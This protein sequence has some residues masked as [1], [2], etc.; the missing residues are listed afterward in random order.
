MFHSIDS[1]NA[2]SSEYKVHRIFSEISNYIEFYK[3]L[4]FSVFAL[5]TPGTTAICNLDSYL[6]S[7]IQ[8]T[9]ESIKLVLQNGRINDSYSLARK[10]YDS[11]VINIYENL[12]L[13]DNFSINNFVVKKI[14]DWLHGK[15]KLPRY[16]AMMKYIQASKKL[17]KVNV[18]LDMEQNGHYG[19]IRKRCNDHAHYNL[20]LCMMMNDN[21]VFIGN[22]IKI[23]DELSDDIR[24][25]F[26]MHFIWLF[27]MN[28][29]YMMSSD[30]VDSMDC[31]VTPIEGSQ[32]YVSPFVQTIFDSVIKA[33]RKDLAK[34][35]MKTTCMKL[36]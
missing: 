7:S 27:T 28:E 34:E 32:Y 21:E 26:I 29:C 8:G 13:Q 19:R 1:N 14:N 36:E 5:V 31:G 25:L 24:D 12:Y 15:E 3:S 9:L 11:I 33:N 22:R 17:A 20:F 4:S 16:D 30:Y 35:L 6:F 10:Y 18:L 2:I 23:L